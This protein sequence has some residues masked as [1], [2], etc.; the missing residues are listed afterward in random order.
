MNNR[1][2]RQI[3]LVD[4]DKLNGSSVICIGAGGV[5]VPFLMYI[6]PTP[7]GPLIL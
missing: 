1:Y 5:G 2:C 6:A 7:L 4:Q 3:E